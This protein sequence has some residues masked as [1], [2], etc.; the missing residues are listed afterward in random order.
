[1]AVNTAKYPT[2]SGTGQSGSPRLTFDYN[3]LCN[4]AMTQTEGTYL[5]DDSICYA[6]SSSRLN[7]S[8]MCQKTYYQFGFDFDEND[9]VLTQLERTEISKFPKAGVMLAKNNSG[10]TTEPYFTSYGSGQYDYKPL[11]LYEYQNRYGEMGNADSS[12][13]NRS[14]ITGFDWWANN[15]GIMLV[16]MKFD[17]TNGYFVMSTQ[18][19][20]AE[21]LKYVTYDVYM[22]TY[23]SDTTWICVGAYLYPNFSNTIYG[24]VVSANPWCGYNTPRYSYSGFAPTPYT[25]KSHRVFEIDTSA[26]WIDLSFS[27][28]VPSGGNYERTMCGG[29]YSNVPIV[30]M[31]YVTFAQGVLTNGNKSY[32]RAFKNTICGI[33]GGSDSYVLTEVNFYS[34]TYQKIYNGYI[35]VV[36]VNKLIS[37]ACSYGLIVSTVSN[38]LWSNWYSLANLKTWAQNNQNKVFI[39]IPD[40]NGCYSGEYMELHD[41]L[42]NGSKEISPYYPDDQED[43]TRMRV[44]PD[45]PYDTSQGG[46]GKDSEDGDIDETALNDVKLNAIGV[47]N[48]CF[49]VS[50]NDMRDLADYIYNADE[51]T[52]EAIQ[53]GVS[54]MGDNPSNALI[55][56]V[57]TPFDIPTMITGGGVL[58]YIKLG[59]FT[60]PVSGL[61]LP[62][63][64]SSIFDF[65]ELDVPYPSMSNPIAN[66]PCFLDY[67]P[68]TTITLYIPYVG[69]VDLSAKEVVG[70]KL[71]VRLI[72]D[73]QTN[74]TCGTVFVNGIMLTYRTGTINTSIEMNASNRAVN[75]AGVLRGVVDTGVS[76]VNMVAGAGGQSASQWLSGFSGLL[77][78][79]IN[80]YDSIAQPSQFRSIGATTSSNAQYLP[81]YPFIVMSTAEDMPSENYGRA[82]GYACNEYVALNFHGGFTVCGGTTPQVGRTER[83][84]V[85]IAEALHEGVIV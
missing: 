14:L 51:S 50:L 4:T 42:T 17:V 1:M 8:A 7:V 37:S 31:F 60:T 44:D 78:S 41:F 23:V 34:P 77:H 79:Q 35:T 83:E 55:S 76:A 28:D 13:N 2:Q 40:D 67:E 12:V 68:Y 56:L 16:L 65:G 27:T 48:R 38:S 49:A 10:V 43:Y 25:F 18:G 19:V 20:P 71:N 84:N 26:S 82:I 5:D 30:D 6:T 52:A 45:Y 24:T 64:M 85:L 73:W 80:I 75:V 22:S 11:T 32:S 69:I 3:Y 72:I 62:S 54:F 58:G 39:P 70:K 63:S 53:R 9:V 36:N 66:S 33:R 46:G 29:G 57:Q 81:P 59:R 21:P 61:I 47:F 15:C 74:T